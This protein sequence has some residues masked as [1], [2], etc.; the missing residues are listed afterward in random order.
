[1]Y[2]FIVN[3]TDGGFKFPFGNAQQ[4]HGIICAVRERLCVDGKRLQRRTG[5][6]GDAVQGS[7]SPSAHSHQCKVGFQ[8]NGIRMG[9]MIQL[10]NDLLFLLHQCLLP[11]Q[12][13]E[14]ACMEWC[15]FA[16]DVFRTE[17][18][19]DFFRKRRFVFL[20]GLADHHGTEAFFPCNAR[21]LTAG[22]LAGA[23]DDFGAF[24]LGAVCIFDANGDARFFYGEHGIFMEDAGS[25]A[26]KPVQFPIGDEPNGGGVFD[27]PRV[28][29]KEARNIGPVFIKHRRNGSCRK[30][31]RNVGAASG[32]GSDLSCGVCTVKA[33]ENGSF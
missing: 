13:Q 14:L 8:K 3:G 28:C 2:E 25:H 29:K 1:M 5:I 21:D 27:D 10:G 15:G 6:G 17:N 12:K 9:G 4:K 16:G 26:G 30:R 20:C 23:A 11:H 7:S 33:R 19:E 22:L 31:P 18:T 32:K 24:I